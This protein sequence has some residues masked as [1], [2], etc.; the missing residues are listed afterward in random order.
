MMDVSCIFKGNL[1]CRPTDMYVEAVKPLQ[2]RS[3]AAVG[4]FLR[5]HH[6]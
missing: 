6:L 3:N 2:Q 1:V 5:R 4:E